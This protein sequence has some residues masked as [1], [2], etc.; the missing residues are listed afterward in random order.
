MISNQVIMTDVL[1]HLIAVQPITRIIYHWFQPLKTRT[2]NRFV[3][4]IKH[5]TDRLE[6]KCQPPLDYELKLMFVV[7]WIAP[8]INIT[9]GALFCLHDT[10]ANCDIIPPAS[11][12]V[13]FKPQGLNVQ[14]LLQGVCRIVQIW[15]RENKCKLKDQKCKKWHINQ[16]VN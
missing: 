6:G 13:H 16:E 10:S 3:H 5:S 11:G 15:E 12:R 2:G 14:G 9:L 4:K 7:E 8:G 1:F